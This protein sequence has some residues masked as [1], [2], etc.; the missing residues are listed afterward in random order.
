MRKSARY[1]TQGA[2]IAA[3]YA[4]LT[5]ALEPFSFAQIQIRIAEAMC[6]LPL[7]T[8]A[9]VPGLTIGCLVANIFGSPFGWL[10]WVVGTSA[11]LLAALATYI[12]RRWKWISPLYAV[13]FNAF[14]VGFVLNFMG[15]WPFWPS[16]GFVAVGETI[17]CFGLGLPLMLL[18]EKLRVHILVESETK[19][20]KE[21]SIRP[22]QKDDK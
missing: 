11:T 13:I 21:R 10:D 12:L 14:A 20:K 18:M 2:I 3:S 9:A 7:F 19:M 6:I 5:L 17:A 22:N 4:G 16:V 8:P 1:I 15:G